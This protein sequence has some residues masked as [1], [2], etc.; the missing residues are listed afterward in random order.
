MQ[1]GS[2]FGLSPEDDYP[3]LAPPDGQ[4]GFGENHAFWL[5]AEDGSV[6]INAHLNSI[7]SFWPLRREA[8]S[9]CLPDGRALVEM[10]EGWG[11]TRDTIVAGGTH[12]RFLE[13]MQRWHVGYK[14]TMRETTQD[15]L[16]RG[17]LADG[18]GRRMLVDWD[19]EITSDLPLQRQGRTEED[20]ESLRKSTATGLIGGS[21]YEQLCRAQVRLRIHGDREYRFAATATRTHR[22]GVRK[23]SEWLRAEWQ[24]ALFPGGNGFY[25]QRYRRDDGGVEWEEASILK[26]GKLHRATIHADN[27]ITRRA[28]SGDKLLLRLQSDL[29][30]AEIEGEVASSIFRSARIDPNDPVPRERG[31]LDRRFGFEASPHRTIALQQACA[32]YKWDG[33]TTYGVCE[34]HNFVD[35]FIA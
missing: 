29:G 26:E 4:P 3:V 1:E 10:N 23:L 15:A 9:I 6:F 28:A 35:Q 21:R 2:N 30:T 31:M 12:A 19:A 20:W 17:D 33:E 27:W 13:P 25:L 34:R 7:D 11:T 24:T 22:A 14:G 32:R 16:A 18:E 5:F 8:V